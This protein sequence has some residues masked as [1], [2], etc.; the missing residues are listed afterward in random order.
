MRGNIFKSFKNKIILKS[1]IALLSLVICFVLGVYGVSFLLGP[2]SLTAEQNTLYYSKTGEIIG[3]EK[4]LES[5]YW[6]DLNRVSQNVINAMVAIEDK[7]FYEHHGFDFKRIIKASLLNMQKMS[8]QEGASTLTQQYAR[9]LYLSHEKTW[10]RKLKEAFYTIRLEMHYSKDEILAGYLNTIYFGHGAYGIEAA[11]QYFFDKSAEHLSLGEATMLV[12]IPKGPT[13]FSPLNDEIKAKGR[14]S[15]ILN[16][17]LDQGKITEEDR[18]LASAESLEYVRKKAQREERIGPYFQDT[19]LSEASDLLGLD[20][21]LIKSGGYHIHTTLQPELQKQLESKVAKHLNSVSDIQV[22]ALAMNP[23]TGSIQALVG[24]KRYDQSPF[25]RA[26][27]AKRMAGSTFKPFLYYTALENN[28]TAATK[29][30]SKPTAFMLED[31]DIYKPSNFNGYYANEPITLAQALALSDNIYAV[32][33]NLSLGIDKLV[34]TARHFGFEGDLPAVPSLALGT[35]ST[36]VKEMVTAYSML[37]NGGQEI[38]GHTIERIVD[39]YGKVVYERK[40]KKGKQILDPINTFILTHLLTGMFD[41]SLNGYTAVTGSPIIDQLTHEY[42][43]KSGS[44]KS[45]SW[46]IGYSPYLVTGVWTGYDDNRSIDNV[47][48]MGFAKSIW[49]EFMEVAHKHKS[50][51][52]FN[53]PSGVVSLPIDTTTGQIATPYCPTHTLMYFKKGTEPKHHCTEHFPENKEEKSE[54][55]PKDERG[56]FQRLFD[57]FN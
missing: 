18:K 32:K 31:D 15:N 11:S 17:L 2:P 45:D 38:A 19:V 9:N 56:F 16:A 20:P 48:E 52:K 8:L 40:Y 39:R 12:G 29:L 43:G 46:M 21:E 24:G 49:A 28:Y 23:T 14:Q 50:T 35:A 51:Q 36:S 13:Y 55:E 53:V 3:E 44:T 22:G 6:I 47:A 37:A 42:A 30:M 4:G 57:L 34:A 25:N 26:T 33:T 27:S 54:Q 41:P 7:R 5:R 10:N 1:I